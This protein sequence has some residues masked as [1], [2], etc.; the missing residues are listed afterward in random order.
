M[1]AP[2]ALAPIV[3]V[4]FYESEAPSNRSRLSCGAWLG[5]SQMEFYDDCRAPPA[6]SGLDAE[7]APIGRLVERGPRNERCASAWRTGEVERGE[8]RLPR[9]RRR[10][11]PVELPYPRNERKE[12]H[13]AGA[14]PPNGS[15]LS[16]GRLARQRDCG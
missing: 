1:T 11:A 9:Q 4:S 15:R 10:S 3:V 8:P 5:S 14:R 12:G 7:P 16:C 2:A 13:G 6:S